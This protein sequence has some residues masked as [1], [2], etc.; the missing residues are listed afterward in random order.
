MI[1]K[2]FLSIIFLR[3]PALGLVHGP[4]PGPALGPAPRSKFFLKLLTWS[5]NFHVALYFFFILI[6]NS[7]WSAFSLAP[8]PCLSASGPA[9]GPVTGPAPGPEGGKAGTLLDLQY[10]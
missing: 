5:V 2:T 4:A 7:F 8:G 6:V 1:W 3:E 10:I 9:P